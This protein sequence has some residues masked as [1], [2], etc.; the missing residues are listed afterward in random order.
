M[1][2]K[3]IATISTIVA[4]LLSQSGVAIDTINTWENTTKQ[5]MKQK[6]D[7]ETKSK[8]VVYCLTLGIQQLCNITEP[9]QEKY[10]VELKKCLKVA[11]H[12]KGVAIERIKE[13]NLQC[14]KEVLYSVVS[15]I[16]IIESV[17]DSEFLT[18]TGGYKMPTDILEFGKG[19]Y[20][21]S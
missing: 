18:F 11:T 17:L 8:N 20:A 6:S 2:G 21:L 3:K 15:F 12:A 1:L 19:L 16:H 13:N 4:L 7:Y 10:R 14:D 9:I 5:E